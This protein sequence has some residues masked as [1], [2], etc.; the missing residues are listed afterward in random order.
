MKQN[1]P[2]LAGSL[3][4]ARLNGVKEKLKFESAG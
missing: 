4:K 2:G 3:V 1:Y